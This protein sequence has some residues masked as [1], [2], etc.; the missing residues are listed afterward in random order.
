MERDILKQSRGLLCS[1]V[2]V[3]FDSVAKHRVIWPVDLTCEALSVSRSGFY[4][5]LTRVPSARSV[6]DAVVG[7]EIR[8]SFRRATAPPEHVVCGTTSRVMPI[9]AACTRSNSQCERRRFVRDQ[10]GK[11]A[12][13]ML[14]PAMRLH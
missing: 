14:V 10:G 9:T 5:W 8:T 6:S 1:G 7:Q 13:S 11:N 3:N 12:L 4:S 2:D